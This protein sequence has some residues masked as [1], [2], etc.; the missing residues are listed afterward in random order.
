MQ[1]NQR[2]V[3]QCLMNG[4]TLQYLSKHLAYY[5]PPCLLRSKGAGALLNVKGKLRRFVAIVPVS[6]M[7]TQVRG[8]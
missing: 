5:D 8:Q 2:P 7:I 1:K 6:P 4:L 3:N